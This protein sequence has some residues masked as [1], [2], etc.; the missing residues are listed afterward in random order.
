M[1]LF[2]SLAL[3]CLFT[4]LTA[5]SVVTYPYNPDS[6]DDQYIAVNDVLSTISAFGQ[7]F[8]P[9]EIMIDGVG[10]STVINDL[11]TIVAAQQ[12]YIDELQQYISVS[13][14]TVL[15]TGA[16]L[17]VVSGGG[18]TDATVN[19]TGNI[20]IGYNED[21]GDDK[22]GSHNLVV[23]KRHSYSTF[24][25]IVVGY[26]HILSGSYGGVLGGAGNIASGFGST[27]SGGQYNSA[28]NYYCSVLG[29][30]TNEASGI[31]SSISGGIYNEVSGNQSSIL[32]GQNIII[33]GESSSVLGGL[34]NAVSGNHCV[35]SGGS[36]NNSSGERTSIVGGLNNSTSG[37]NSTVLGG[38]NNIA[39]GPISVFSEY[40]ETVIGD[41]GYT[42]LDNSADG[43]TID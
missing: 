39:G 28:T 27:I 26:D 16:N 40:R 37:D 21:N 33:S 3:I 10:L 38:R 29:G 20:I 2:F 7:P 9:A 17:Q 31:A 41:A 14:E 36:D 13:N 6:D 42:F 1:R 24:G 23:G 30:Y 43:N 11:Q 32:G 18:S 5:Q 12:L 8:T 15:I 34:N 22:S 4:T 35:I 19:G 25:G